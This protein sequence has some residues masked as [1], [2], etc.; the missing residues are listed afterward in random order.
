MLLPK[1]AGKVDKMQI[2]KQHEVFKKF[3][4]NQLHR[5]YP[6]L[7]FDVIVLSQTIR[8][9]SVATKKP[10]GMGINGKRIADLPAYT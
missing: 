9:F 1:K 10:E 3:A 8:Q 7:H 6:H 2:R 4:Q 5:M